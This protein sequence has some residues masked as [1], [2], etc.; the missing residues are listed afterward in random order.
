[1][2]G[3]TGDWQAL[4]DLSLDATLLVT[5]PQADIDRESGARLKLGGHI[6]L[7]LA[8]SYRLTDTWSVFGRIDNVFDENYQ[9]PE[10]F[11]RPGIGAI[12]GLKV[13]L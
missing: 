12:A 10:G 5:G 7:N 9:S 2:L 11:L 3:L 8:A 6:L 1:M 4:P 13:N